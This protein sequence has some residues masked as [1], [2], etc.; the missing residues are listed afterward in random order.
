MNKKA[1]RLEAIRLWKGDFP[2]LHVYIF[3]LLAVYI[4]PLSAV[5]INKP[6]AGI[7][8]DIAPFGIEQ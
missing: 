2:K 3:L 4:I 8:I 5:D 7:T 6:A 1:V